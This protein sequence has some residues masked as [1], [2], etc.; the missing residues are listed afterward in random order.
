MNATE[1]KHALEGNAITREIFRGVFSSD[2]VP[3]T[4]DTFPY[5]YVVNTD[6]TSKPGAHWI[7]VYQTQPGEVETFVSFGRDFTSYSSHFD[8]MQQQNRIISH[9]CQLKSNFSTVCGQY[10]LFFLLRRASAE[11]YSHIIHLFTD[12]KKSNDI[13]VCQYVNH[14]FDLKTPLQDQDFLGQIN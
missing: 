9:S 11:S 6:R 4:F 10:C 14:F 13:M 7:A 5:E 2:T 12:Y 8:G 1:I 3:D